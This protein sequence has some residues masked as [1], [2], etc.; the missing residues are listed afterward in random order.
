[1]KARI[2]D[3]KDIAPRMRSPISE[4]L[5]DQAQIQRRLTLL[6][7]AGLSAF[8]ATSCANAIPYVVGE[9]DLSSPVVNPATIV[10]FDE[11]AP[12]TLLDG[13]TIKGFTFSE[14]FPSFV[15]TLNV[16]PPVANHIS[17]SL[18]ASG[19][20]FYF[21]SYMLTIDMPGL[22]NAFGFGFALMNNAPIANAFTI[23][24]FNGPNNLGAL[25]YGA[26][27][28]PESDGG[29]AG[30]G[31]TDGFT[32]VQIAFSQA[33]PAFVFDNM[34]ATAIPEPASLRLFGTGAVVLGAWM[35]RYRRQRG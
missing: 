34:A 2:N 21:P 29:F 8:V 30:I 26:A 6:V 12:G 20:G 31:H 25:T 33:V 15:A 27:P 23:T 1:M 9:A 19:A 24:L 3:R 28:D 17:G 18:A 14:T 22:E 5:L 32:R 35:W 11:V 10:H 7:A 13:T 16:G 4:V